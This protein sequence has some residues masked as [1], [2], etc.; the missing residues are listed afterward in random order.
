MIQGSDEQQG[1]FTLSLDGSSTTSIQAEDLTA[2]VVRGAL[3]DIDT[4]GQV[5]VL[6]DYDLFRTIGE[7]SVKMTE[8]SIVLVDSSSSYEAHDISG[9]CV[10]SVQN[11]DGS[12]TSRERTEWR[13]GSS[14]HSDGY[15]PADFYAATLQDCEARCDL[16]AG[17]VAISYSDSASSSE[18][19]CMPVYDKFEGVDEDTSSTFTCLVRSLS[20]NMNA[21]LT[22]GDVV[23][24][25]G[26]DSSQT[27]LDGMCS[28]ALHSIL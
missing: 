21:E 17:C 26:A 23:R 18:V 19:N 25:G 4:V 11:G 27:F 8:S 13:L 1:T 28:S 7:V 10:S 6:Q 12:E 24:I 9:K 2:E 20:A 3:D 5:Q 15:F 22:H 14:A 16:S